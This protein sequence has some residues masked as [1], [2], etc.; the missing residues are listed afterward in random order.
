MNPL[1]NNPAARKAV[2]LVFWLVGLVLGALT[3]G[4]GAADAAAPE[5]LDVALAVYA[6]LGAAVGYTAQ[7]NVMPGDDD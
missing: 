7:S 1:S 2:Y 6:F 3:A 5:H 4:Y